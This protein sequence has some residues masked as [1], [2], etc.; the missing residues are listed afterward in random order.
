[1]VQV[2]YAQLAQYSVTAWLWA[3]A[4]PGEWWFGG[5]KILSRAEAGDALT[6]LEDQTPHVTVNVV[7]RTL[8]AAGL[9][10]TPVVQSAQP[11]RRKK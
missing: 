5:R 8:R 11:T 2:N 6:A 9:T 10:S 4:E 3:W 1:M 7:A